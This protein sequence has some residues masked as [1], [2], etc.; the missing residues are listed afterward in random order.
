MTPKTITIPGITALLERFLRPAA[1]TSGEG[2]E[3][4]QDRHGTVVSA[5]EGRHSVTVSNAVA[6]DLEP[7][8]IDP[9][10]LASADPNATIKLFRLT[11][12]T[13]TIIG[14]AGEL[15]DVAIRPGSLHRSARDM[16]TVVEGEVASGMTKQVF[17]VDPRHLLA[18]AE[19]MVAAGAERMTVAVAPRWNVLSCST[20]TSEICATFLIAGETFDHADPASGGSGKDTADPMSFTI[21]EGRRKATG[22]TRRRKGIDTSGIP[23]NEIPW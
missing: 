14:S 12:T 1:A 21:G 22:P 6:G 16:A 17:E 13:G 4:R 19:A 18:V 2:I 7:I 9:A 15:L 5:L 3:I 8:L 11:E 20:E 10:A 23:D